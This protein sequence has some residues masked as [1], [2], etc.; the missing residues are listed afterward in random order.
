METLLE[1]QPKHPVT[2]K[3]I[4]VRELIKDGKKR[5]VSLC[6]DSAPL[7]EKLIHRLD[8]P[9]MATSQQIFIMYGNLIMRGLVTKNVQNEQMQ[10]QI[11]NNVCEELS[12][13]VFQCVLPRIQ[14]HVIRNSIFLP[15][16]PAEII[17]IHSMIVSHFAPEVQITRIVAVRSLEYYLKTQQAKNERIAE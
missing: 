13:Q 17:K 7:T 14:K 16:V 2:Q 9:L 5:V 1:D 10:E 6:K 3:I 8:N 12:G 4:A 15:I 11:L